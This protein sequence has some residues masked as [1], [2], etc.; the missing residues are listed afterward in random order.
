MFIAVVP[1]YRFRKRKNSYIG[2]EQQNSR[3]EEE[4]CFPEKQGKRKLFF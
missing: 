1:S 3:V 2:R 4:E